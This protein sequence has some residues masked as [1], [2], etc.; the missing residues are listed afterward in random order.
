M[1]ECSI[2]EGTDLSGMRRVMGRGA[3]LARGRGR[4]EQ[5]G[6]IVTRGLACDLVAHDLAVWVLGRA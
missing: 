1:L 6:E 4:R 5:T 2:E 3:R